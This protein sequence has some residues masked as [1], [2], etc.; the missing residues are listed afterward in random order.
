MPKITLRGEIGT[1]QKLGWRSSL[2]EGAQWQVLTN[3]TLGAEGTVVVDLAAS[4]SMRFYRVST[5]VSTSSEISFVTL[6]DAGNA[7]DTTMYGAVGYTFQIQKFEFTNAEYV[8]F[9]NAAA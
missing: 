8:E 1:G 5:S 4:S 2:R 6:G 3:V 9:L 7:A